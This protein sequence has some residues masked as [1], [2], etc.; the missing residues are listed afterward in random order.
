MFGIRAG[1]DAIDGV[2]ELDEMNSPAVARMGHGHG[3]IGVNVSG[4]AAEHDDAVG[5]DN[6][7]FDVAGDD[8]DGAGGNFAP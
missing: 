1:E 8:E 3:N 7:F 2:N 4:V 6:G 5:K